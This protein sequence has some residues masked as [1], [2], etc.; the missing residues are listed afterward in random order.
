MKPINIYNYE[1]KNAMK[2]VLKKD[3]KEVFRGSEADAWKYIHNR[4]GFSVCHA[5]TYEGYEITNP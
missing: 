1:L 5:I 3:N 2:C 4:H